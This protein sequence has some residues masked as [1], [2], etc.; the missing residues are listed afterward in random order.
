MPSKR[1]KDLL[2]R[3]AQTVVRNYIATH[4]TP[5]P[6][7]M[8]IPP[9]P[10]PTPIAVP[11]PALPPSPP[12]VIPHP[13]EP[14]HVTIPPR[15]PDPPP[16]QQPEPIATP[17]VLPSSPPVTIVHVVVIDAQAI[18]PSIPS[19][20]TLTSELKEERET[21]LSMAD[22]NGV[23]QADML[24][25]LDTIYGQEEDAEEVESPDR[26]DSPSSLMTVY[27]NLTTPRMGSPGVDIFRPA[28]PGPEHTFDFCLVNSRESKT[29]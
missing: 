4:A 10:P 18:Q 3:I 5:V 26:L 1:P 6:T 11:I 13:P 23:S 12:P 9:T 29:P 22:D 15:M 2:Q 7:V 24:Q 8:P 16:I 25:M 14:V 27:E 17:Q 28:T 19:S 21:F 20:P